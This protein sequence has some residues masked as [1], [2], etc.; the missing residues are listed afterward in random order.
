MSEEEGAGEDVDAFGAGGEEGVGAGVAGGAGGEDVV[1]KEDGA[2]AD[3]GAAAGAVGAFGVGEAFGA[4]QAGLREDAGVDAPEE[5]GEVGEVELL[6]EAAGEFLGL[7]VA[8]V[9]AFAPEHGDGDDGVDAQ[10]EGAMR[11]R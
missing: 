9:E 6:G 1:D 3:G 10:A 4:G 5:A 11:A 7:V 8:A 2:A